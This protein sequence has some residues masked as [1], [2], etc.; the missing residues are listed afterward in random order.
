MILPHAAPPVH[1][2]NNAQDMTANLPTIRKAL[3]L[4]CEPGEVAELRIL[5]TGRTGTVSG[6]FNDVEAMA[7]AAAQWSGR[8]PGV[9]VTLNP[10]SAALLARA[11]NR[12]IDR[13]QQTTSDV[14]IVQR[15]WLPIDFDPV[16]PAGI[17]STTGEHDAAV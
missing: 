14:D 16:R 15:R 4:L 2:T 10:C 9:Y 13:A 7:Q 8:A 1:S 5:H 11:A 6:Y 3:T 12:L 17:S